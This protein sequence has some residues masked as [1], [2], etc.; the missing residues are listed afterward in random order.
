V[1]YRIVQSGNHF[2]WVVATYYVCRLLERPETVHTQCVRVACTVF[3]ASRPCALE[4]HGPIGLCSETRSV[5]WEVRAEFVYIAC[6]ACGDSR[7]T[8]TRVVLFNDAVSC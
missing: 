6:S 5:R 1:T 2:R 8:G 3:T 7:D 4:L